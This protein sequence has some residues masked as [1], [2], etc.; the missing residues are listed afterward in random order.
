MIQEE[1]ATVDVVMHND[2][3]TIMKKYSPSKEDASDTFKDIFWQQLKAAS[4]KDLRWQSF[5]GVFTFTTTPVAV[6][7]L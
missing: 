1:G 6:T 7:T 4:L 2:L 5:D 3:L